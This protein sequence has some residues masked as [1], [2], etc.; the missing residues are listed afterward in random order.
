[1]AAKIMVTK[2]SGELQEFS[3]EKLQASLVKAGAD[4]V[5][6]DEIVEHISGQVFEG[7]G[8][9]VIHDRAFA[10]LKA[11][12]GVAAARY[13][14]KRAVAEFGPSGFPFE[15][16]VARLFDAMGYETA[17]G[18]VLQGKCIPHEIDVVLTNG[19][20]HGLVECKF[21]A[22]PGAKCDVKVPLYVHSRFEDILARRGDASAESE[23][24]IVTNS[25][26]SDDASVYG[27][28]AGLKLLGWNNG[29]LGESLLRLIDA[30]GLHP[31]TCLTSLTTERKREL[32]AAG[33]VLCRDFLD[34]ARNEDAAA[35]A[36]AKELCK[37]F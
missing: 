24:W 20:I 23:G 35:V 2:A 28:C 11:H 33:I 15:R 17:V 27:A 34:V 14:L 10:M 22:T 26:F 18:V 21:H 13:N 4:P 29:P 31:V 3:E 36:E 6:A 16:Y 19:D 8:T 25:R 12:Q 1:M 5:L 9:S 30:R 37:H 32:L 7:M